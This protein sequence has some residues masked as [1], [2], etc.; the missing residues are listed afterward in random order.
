VVIDCISYRKGA[1]FQHATIGGLHPGRT[2][3]SAFRL[4]I[5]GE[6]YKALQV[7]FIRTLLQTINGGLHTISK[8]EKHGKNGGG[9]GGIV[10]HHFP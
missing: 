10:L 8:I 6:L 5:E 7:S 9:S 1:I 4:A 2:D 3:T